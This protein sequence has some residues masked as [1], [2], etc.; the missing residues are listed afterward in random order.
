MATVNVTKMAESVQDI[1]IAFNAIIP[2]KRKAKMI[3]DEL[4]EKELKP[5][6]FKRLM[7]KRK[8]ENKLMI[9]AF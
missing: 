3:V 7:Q 2:K 8:H 6:N 1:V 5:L 9:F 4:H